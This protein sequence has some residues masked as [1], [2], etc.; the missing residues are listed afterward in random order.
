LLTSHITSITIYN[1]KD[2]IIESWIENDEW[3]K[4]IGIKKLCVRFKDETGL[5]LP[6][7]TFGCLHPDA[8]INEN[9]Y[10]G[11]SRKEA[12]KKYVMTYFKKSE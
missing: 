2:Q 1:M 10:I 12:C 8:Q 11:L 7:E 5:T 4:K 9:D 6:A 3:C